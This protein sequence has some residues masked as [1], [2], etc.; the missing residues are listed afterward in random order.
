L[1]PFISRTPYRVSFFGGGSDYP[2]WYR[3]HGGIVL[4]S[5][6]DKYCYISARYFP[7]FF[8]N[9]HR[10]VWKYVE[11]VNAIAEILHPAVREGLRYLD[12]DDERG[13]EIHY[14]GDLPARSGVGSGSSFAVGLIHSLLAMRGETPD[15]HALALKAIELEQDWLKDSVGSQDQ[16][17]AAHGGLNVIRF[18]EDGSI[19]VDPLALSE[20]RRREFEG[21]LLLFFTG[22]SRL[23]SEVARDVIVNLGRRRKAIREMCALVEPAVE[24]L[25]GGDLNDFG[26]MLDQSWRLKRTLADCVSNSVI[27]EIYA[28]AMTAGAL[29]GKLLGA[30]QSGFMLFFAPPEHH[31]AIRRALD[32]YLYVPM[33]LE[34]TGSRLIYR[35]DSGPEEGL[36]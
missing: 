16:V 30:G 17:A 27:D 21:H 2:K 12:F 29:G 20:Q 15:Q 9:K 1:T 4:S 33:R 14:Q 6:I 24:I 3:R 7:G 23:A 19:Q 28:T 18:H 34:T 36:P 32:R 22:V 31:A 8:E 35:G 11:T 5:S 13:M 25:R 26:R 10:I